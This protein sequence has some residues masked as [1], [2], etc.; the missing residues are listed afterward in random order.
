VDWYVSPFA[1]IGLKFFELV[2]MRVGW[3]ADLGENDY[4]VHTGRVD[5]GFEF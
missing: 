4:T 3:E 2:R 5:F 1:G